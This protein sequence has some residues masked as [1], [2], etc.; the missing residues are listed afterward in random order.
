MKELIDIARDSMIV[1]CGITG[2]CMSIICLMVGYKLGKISAKSQ[3]PP[4]EINI[5]LIKEY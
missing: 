2:A 1:I 5:H 4:Q 3:A